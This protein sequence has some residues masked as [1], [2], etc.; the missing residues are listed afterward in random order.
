MNNSG[1]D[2]KDLSDTKVQL[3]ED[4][5]HYGYSISINCDN[6]YAS[7]KFEAEYTYTGDDLGATYRKESTTF[8]VWAPTAKK[9]EVQ[10]YATGSD[11]EKGAK[12]L[13]TYSMTGGS[14]NDK[15]VWTVTV[16]KDFFRN[17]I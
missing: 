1:L 8:K 13:G 7:D 10:L 9:V 6:M 15:G 4:T 11:D 14:K 17:L 16:P 5:K 12:T 3:T 2:L